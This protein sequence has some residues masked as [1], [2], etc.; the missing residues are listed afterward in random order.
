M[1][2]LNMP[3]QTL[4]PFPSTC[5]FLHFPFFGLVNMVPKFA[6]RFYDQ[7]HYKKMR[8]FCKTSSCGHATQT[9]WGPCP[10]R[11]KI[12]HR[13]TVRQYWCRYIQPGNKASALLA[14]LIPRYLM[15]S[16]CHILWTMMIQSCFACFPRFLHW[17][18]RY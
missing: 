13:V 10:A 6:P 1:T 8:S 4:N 12:K 3:R 7:R 11:H 15:T 5:R 2:T 17:V 14:R 16:K 18:S 9:Q